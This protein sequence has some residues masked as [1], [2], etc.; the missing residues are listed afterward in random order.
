M[1]LFRHCERI[2]SPKKTHVCIF[3]LTSDNGDVTLAPTSI[4]RTARM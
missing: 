4:V 2:R 1:R 3:P